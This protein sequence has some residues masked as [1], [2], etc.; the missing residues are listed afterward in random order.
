MTPEQTERLMMD[1]Q[2]RDAD[3]RVRFQG[4]VTPLRSGDLLDRPQSLESDLTLAV[5]SVACCAGAGLW[6]LAFWVFCH[7]A[8]LTPLAAFVGVR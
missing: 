7:Q 6:A 2:S 3:N 1:M 4:R 8:V 5:L